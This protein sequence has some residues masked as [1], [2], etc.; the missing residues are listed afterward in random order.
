MSDNRLEPVARDLARRDGRSE[1]EWGVYLEEAA[2][3][4]AE[5]DRA[6]A[7]MQRGINPIPRPPPGLIV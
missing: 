4:V 3:F 1:D 2:A 5:I 6:A 7:D